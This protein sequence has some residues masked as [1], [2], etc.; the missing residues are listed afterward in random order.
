[1]PPAT[2]VAPAVAAEGDPVVNNVFA[3]VA[4]PAAPPV[5]VVA[6]VPLA[7]FAWIALAAALVKSRTLHTIYPGIM[8]IDPAPEIVMVEY[9][10]DAGALTDEVT[11]KFVLEPPSIA[12]SKTLSKVLTCVA[13]SPT[14][15]VPGRI[16]PNNVS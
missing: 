12:A 13:V 1:V 3:V 2:P 14:P 7:P 5:W 6:D 10:V 8:L 11:D 9:V 4:A 16:L 15:V